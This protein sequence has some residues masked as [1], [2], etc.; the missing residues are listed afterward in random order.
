MDGNESGMNNDGDGI[1]SGT[2]SGRTTPRPNNNRARNKKSVATSGLASTST[3]VA[4]F[5]SSTALGGVFQST[6]NNPTNLPTSLSSSDPLLVPATAN[7]STPGI[8]N[9]SHLLPNK[10]NTDNPKSSSSYSPAPPSSESRKRQSRPKHIRMKSEPMVN[11]VSVV[12]EMGGVQR[13][14]GESGATEGEMGRRERSGRQR[15]KAVDLKAVEGGEEIDL[16]GERTRR[17]SKGGKRKDGEAGVEGNNEVVTSKEGRAG[18]KNR[19]ERDVVKGMEGLRIGSKEVDKETGEMNAGVDGGS[20]EE[21]EDEVD[22]ILI[23]KSLD[24]TGTGAGQESSEVEMDST[25]PGK[26]FSRGPET[27][28]LDHTSS[29]KTRTSTTPKRMSKSKAS[30]PDVTMY[31]HTTGDSSAGEREPSIPTNRIAIPTSSSA[32]TQSHS[33]RG[34]QIDGDITAGRYN[35]KFL[36]SSSSLNEGLLSRSVPIGGFLH[37][38]N[39]SGEESAGGNGGIIDGGRS[40]RYKDIRVETVQDLDDLEDNAAWDMPDLDKRGPGVELTWQQTL[41]SSPGAMLPRIGMGSGSGTPIS[42]RGSGGGKKDKI[43]EGMGGGGYAGGSG[44]KYPFSDHETVGSTSGRGQQN[45]RKD[46]TG[47]SSTAE[48]ATTRSSRNKAKSK[49]TESRDELYPLSAIPPY[50]GFSSSAYDTPKKKLLPPST[51]SSSRQRSESEDPTRPAFS[52]HTV[53]A[54]SGSAP[55]G[56]EMFGTPLGANRRNKKVEDLIGMYAG[57]TFHNSPSPDALPAPRLRG[58]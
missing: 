12:G 37:P 14:G 20:D 31:D 55:L 17:V 57:P 49:T 58:H 56:M 44:L 28:A 22:E 46:Q 41:F 53:S 39:D 11:M 24:G 23:G 42:S 54:P 10:N 5:S 51:S 32:S 52:H 50:R 45:S 27:K 33:K 19:R 30:Q 7:T 26:Q 43:R 8:L 3:A 2:G 21:D 9:L 38:H 40:R 4:G 35:G 47:Y 6:S 48:D 1:D 18:D 13:S 29:R 25:S 36:A 34:F 16:K 15:K